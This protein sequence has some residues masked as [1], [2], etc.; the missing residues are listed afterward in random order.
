[1]SDTSKSFHGNGFCLFSFIVLKSPGRS[2]VRHTWNSAVFGLAITTAVFPSSTRRMWPNASS[3]EHSAN[4][5]AS[6]Y[7]A[8]A[9][10]RR[11][12]SVS[13]CS[14]CCEPTHESVGTTRG[15]LLNE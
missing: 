11:I 15:S 2:E 6:V 7:P 1:M 10:S 12:R 9:S 5:S 8:S 3:C 4:V 13:F 14:G